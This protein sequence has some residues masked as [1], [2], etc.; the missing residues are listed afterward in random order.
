MARQKELTGH[1]ETAREKEKTRQ[2]KR[3]YKKEREKVRKREKKEVFARTTCLLTMT[4]K[5]IHGNSAVVVLQGAQMNILET[6]S[7]QLMS[8]IIK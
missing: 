2:I 5:V 1:K 4:S 8:S 7:M 3:Y 6:F